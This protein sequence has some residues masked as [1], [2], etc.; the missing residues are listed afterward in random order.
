MYVFYCTFYAFSIFQITQILLKTNKILMQ[1]YPFYWC[2][3]LIIKGN[4]QCVK[5]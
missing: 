3:S 1:Y 5:K 2:Y 4:I